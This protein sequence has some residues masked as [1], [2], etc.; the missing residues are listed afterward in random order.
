MAIDK[1]VERLNGLKDSEEVIGRLRA[2]NQLLD[3]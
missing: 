3:E 2:K 1:I